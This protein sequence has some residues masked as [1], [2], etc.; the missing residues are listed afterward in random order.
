MIPGQKAKG[1]K[2]TSVVAVD[3]IIGQ[4]TSP[5]AY[6]AASKAL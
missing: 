2:A 3:A 1:I 4:A 6:F 5:T